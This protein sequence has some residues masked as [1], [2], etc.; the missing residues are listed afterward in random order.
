MYMQGHYHLDE[1]DSTCDIVVMDDLPL[2]LL[3]QRKQWWGCQRD[4]IT[5]DKYRVKRKICGGKPLIWICNSDNT[6]RNAQKD[7]KNILGYDELEYFS[8]NSI[9]VDITNK[10]F[11]EYLVFASLTPDRRSVL[12]FASLL[13]LRILYTSSLCGGPQSEF[14]GYVISHVIYYASF[15]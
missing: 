15:Q 5:E 1:W 7:N 3:R 11:L 6:P 10:I 14:F 12:R 4:F 2:H 13:R 8:Q 9:V